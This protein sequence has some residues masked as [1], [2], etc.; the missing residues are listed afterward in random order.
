MPGAVVTVTN[1]ETGISKKAVTDSGGYFQVLALQRGLYSVTVQKTGF[2]T[3]QDELGLDRWRTGDV[4][5]DAE[6]PVLFAHGQ[7]N[8]PDSVV[9]A[10]TEYRRAYQGKLAQHALPSHA[11][12]C[13]PTRTCAAH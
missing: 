11:R 4:F 12:S 1:I 6:L 3:W 9:L 2:T 10:T 8:R 13:K 5:G 7:H